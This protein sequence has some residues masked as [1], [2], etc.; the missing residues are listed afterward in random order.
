[1]KFT[2]VQQEFMDWIDAVV[3]AELD[4]EHT[5]FANDMKFLERDFKASRKIRKEFFEWFKRIEKMTKWK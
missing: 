5:I 1:M 3:M 4:L 2:R